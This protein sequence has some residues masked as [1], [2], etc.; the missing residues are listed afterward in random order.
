VKERVSA[1]SRQGDRDKP[2]QRF[3][4]LYQT[5]YPAIFRYVLRRLAPGSKIEDAADITADVFAT[6]WTRIQKVPPFPDD[7]FWLY[8]VARRALQHHRRSYSRRQ[9]LNLRLYSEAAVGQSL[10]EDSTVDGDRVSDAIAGLR[11]S[12][13]EVFSLIVWDELDNQAVAR[14]LG[15]S[16]NT[17]AV[18]LHRARAR[19]RAQLSQAGLQA[20]Q[21]ESGISDVMPG[22]TKES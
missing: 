16:P 2:R 3:D 20:E 13:R 19:L 8:G 14:I 12:D 9:R 10:T 17:V 7:R 1:V 4:D 22:R 11:A 15:C 5:N 21:T 18:R 6:A